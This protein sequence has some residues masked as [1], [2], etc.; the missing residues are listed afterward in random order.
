MYPEEIWE[1]IQ[2]HPSG[3][4]EPYQEPV[5]DL[6]RELPHN[7]T[8]IDLDAEWGDWLEATYDPDAPVP[9]LPTDRIEDLE[10]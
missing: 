1:A 8:G 4:A 3:K 9:Y 6:Y 2:R 5:E 10:I 7:G